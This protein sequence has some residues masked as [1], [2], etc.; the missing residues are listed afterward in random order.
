LAGWDLHPLDDKPNFSRYRQGGHLATLLALTANQPEF[1]HDFEHVDTSVRG[2]VSF[3]G[4]YDFTN[5]HGQ[6]RHDGMLRVLEQWVM[7][8]LL[9]QS[10]D[11]Y[12]KASPVDWISNQAPPLFVIQG[13]RDTLVPAEEARL[14]VKAFQQKASAQIVYAEVSGAQ[15]AFDLCTTPRTQAVV[16]GVERFL[17]YLHSKYLESRDP[18]A[19]SERM[20]SREARQGDAEN[21]GQTGPSPTARATG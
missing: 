7:K 12:R 3:Y 1:Q 13:E 2:C 20:V 14:F 11:E 15:H 17:A 9:E 4:I 21:R 6:L 16:D 8:A 18:K 5:R 19:Q 10:P